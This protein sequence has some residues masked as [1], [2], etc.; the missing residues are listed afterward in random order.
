MAEGQRKRA[1]DFI[2]YQSNLTLYIPY[3]NPFTSTGAGSI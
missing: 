2:E 3:L 1:S